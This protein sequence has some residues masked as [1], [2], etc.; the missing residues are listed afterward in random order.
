MA[1]INNE[2]AAKI[3]RQQKKIKRKI[4]KIKKIKKKKV[5]AFVR[6]FLERKNLKVKMNLKQQA[7]QEYSLYQKQNI[8][9]TCF[10]FSFVFSTLFCWGHFGDDNIG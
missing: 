10:Y 2:A 8:L 3:H 6:H 5:A 7:K 9:E 1:K 4:K